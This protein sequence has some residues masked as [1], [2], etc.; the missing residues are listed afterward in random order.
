M[1]DDSK[2]DDADT[3]V[4]KQRGRPFKKGQSGNPAGR[5]PGSRHK[6]LVAAELLLD[7]EA[8]KL[9]R[10]AIELA[11][12]GDPACLR[13]CIDRILP[14]RK[15]RPLVGLNIPPVKSLEDVSGAMAAVVEHVT[16]GTMTPSEGAA[17]TGLI[18]SFSDATHLADMTRRLELLEAKANLD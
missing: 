17:V 5:P 2:T 13:L 3:T 16:D 14:P 8:E 6:H 10:K 4:L 15:E 11:L 1:E 9:T 18:Q 7:G 12:D